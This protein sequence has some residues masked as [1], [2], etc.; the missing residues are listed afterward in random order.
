MP[1]LYLHWFQ[2]YFPMVTIPGLGPYVLQCLRLMQGTKLAGHAF[3][4]ILKAILGDA[5]VA[6]TLI[7]FGFYVFVY[8]E[9]YL[10]FLVTNTDDFLLL[11]NSVEAYNL[12]KKE[13]A[14]V[15]SVLLQIGSR[16]NYLN[17][18]I[19]QRVLIRPVISCAWWRNTLVPDLP[20]QRRPLHFVRT[21][22]LIRK[23][24]MTNQQIFRN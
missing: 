2:K 7:D 12:I 5:G 24:W 1:P 6:P 23:L 15:F 21:N 3:Y 17:F 14:S 4:K 18:L 16:I 8:K 20:R 13:I 10:V 22:S 9:K 11:M 19:Y